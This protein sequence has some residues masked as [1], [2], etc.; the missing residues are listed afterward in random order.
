MLGVNV[1][2][3]LAIGDTMEAE[4]LEGKLAKRRRHLIRQ[5]QAELDSHGD[6]GQAEVRRMTKSPFI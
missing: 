2:E 5:M 6:I 3:A 4:S 1:S